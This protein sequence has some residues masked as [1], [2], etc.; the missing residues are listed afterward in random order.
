MTLY[1]VI[2][3]LIALQSMIHKGDTKCITLTTANKQVRNPVI[4]TEIM[5][6]VVLNTSDGATLYT[7]IISRNSNADETLTNKSEMFK[8]AK[9]LVEEESLFLVVSLDL[10]KLK[11]Y[12]KD[13]LLATVP[14]IAINTLNTTMMLLNCSDPG[15][16]PIVNR[17]AR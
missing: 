6:R 16:S 11:K 3:T 2:H 5:Q 10:I 15:V 7:N 4:S 8:A 1:T 14:N 13:K 9:S 12:D 17:Y